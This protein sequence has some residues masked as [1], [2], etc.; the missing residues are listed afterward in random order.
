MPNDHL[1]FDDAVKAETTKNVEK[2][3][4]MNKRDSLLQTYVYIILKD[5]TNSGRRMSQADIMEALMEYPFEL[6]V[7]RRT[8]ARAI[9]TLEDNFFGIHTSDKGSWHEK[10]DDWFMSNRPGTW[11]DAA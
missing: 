11:G 7:N 6:E 9:N 2:S 5:R 8:L 4:D 10:M 1:S 3:K